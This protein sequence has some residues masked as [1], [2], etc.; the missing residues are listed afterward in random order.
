MD[1]EAW[2]EIADLAVAVGITPRAIRKRLH[3]FTAR[4]VKGKGG[5]SG[6]RYQLLLSSLPDAWQAAWW[7]R[8]NALPLPWQDAVLVK[9][10]PAPE[11]DPPIA[12]PVPIPSPAPVPMTAGAGSIA[13]ISPLT[14]AV[15]LSSPTASTALVPVPAD[16]TSHL[17]D[18]QRR[19][20]HARLAVLRELDRLMLEHGPG[21]GK[22][23]LIIQAR[24][25]QLPP[26]L[27]AQLPYALG[28]R[29]STLSRATLA[30]W[31]R[32]S[33][34]GLIHLAPRPKAHGPRVPAWA[35]YFL[36]FWQR[37]Q[38]PSYVWALEQIAAP[39]VLPADIKLPSLSAI[40]RFVKQM[41]AVDRN[42]GRLGPRQLRNLRPYRQR[43]ASGLWPADIFSMDGHTFDAEVAHPFHGQP[44]R[45]E[46]T[47][48]IDIATRKLVGWSVALAE[49]S[50]AVLDALRHSVQSHGIPNEL[51]VDNGSGYHNVLMEAQTIGFMDRLG[52]TKTHSR[53]FRSQARGAIER[54]HQTVWVRLAKAFDTYL[55]D[56][57]DKEV[58]DRV[59]KITRQEI[60]AAGASRLLPSFP[61][62]LAR[63][64]AAVA[65]Y[66]ARPHSSLPLIVDPLTGRKRHQSPNEIWAELVQQNPDC[67]VTIRDTEAADLFRPYKTGKVNRGQV[68][69]FG[70]VYFSR[71][72]E[73]HH[74]DSVFIGYDIH[75]AERV[76]VRDR[77]QVL[78]TVA[79][80]DAN[81]SDYRPQTALEH[82]NAKRATARVIRLERH[83]EEVHLELT[84]SRPVLE[85]R[86]ATPE[87]QAAA[88]EYLAES[89]PS[90]LVGEG[91]GEGESG[92][93][94]RI[95]RTDLELYLWVQDHPAL[96]NDQDRAY[97]AECL[98]DESFRATCEAEAQ[99][100][101]R[102][103]SSA[104]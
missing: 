56:P 15:A 25:E 20:L 92:Q 14:D 98:E 40:G 87:E 74:G 31:Q 30:R 85:G 5:A 11:P 44:F 48:T 46:I 49:S 79:R 41:N 28:R 9:A 4:P 18:W 12:L 29:D 78:L 94:P 1:G 101:S 67:L 75:D 102:L 7:Q 2:L 81:K 53:A 61:V 39:G 69:I 96:A 3:S 34:Q 104:A 38:K 37:P 103:K 16:D 76:W 51:Y 90:P 64:E 89:A 84:G 10:L 73:G 55:G 27:Q 42:R 72:L 35:P 24:A 93:R 57:M 88:A 21:R 91:R 70:N 52:I 58:R 47:S 26:E 50:L 23:A 99:K 43:D 65:D 95:F 62:F 80:L 45:P 66:N 63:C 100:K 54:L 33:A 6:T 77:N 86:L 36:K 17:K 68:R 71:D 8:V 83:L 60:K 97:L 32:D 13:S 22:D 82:N 19:R 59:H